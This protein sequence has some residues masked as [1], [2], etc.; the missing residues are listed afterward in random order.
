MKF[1]DLFREWERRHGPEVARLMAMVY[2]DE[3]F[4]GLWAGDWA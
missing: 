4:R 1:I 2:W 3:F